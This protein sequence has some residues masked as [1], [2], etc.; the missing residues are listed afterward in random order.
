[1][2]N[3]LLLTAL[4]LSFVVNIHAQTADSLV[5][6]ELEKAGITFSDN[7]SVVLLMD[8]QEKFDDM[9]AAIRQARHSV[10]LE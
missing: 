5:V 4:C 7:N 8:G 1:M 2:K 9:F 6:Q 10:H 3:F